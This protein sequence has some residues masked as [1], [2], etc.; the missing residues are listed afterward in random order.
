[1]NRKRQQAEILFQAGQLFGPMLK[2]VENPESY[3]QD[4]RTRILARYFADVQ[5]FVGNFREFIN[6]EPGHIYEGQYFK[7]MERIGPFGSIAGLSSF[8]H[9]AD[10]VKAL[11]AAVFDAIYSIPVPIDSSIHEAH[12]PFSTYCLV[13]A[14]CSTARARIDW[15]DRYFDATLFGRYFVDVPETSVITLVT[16]PESRC[17]GAKDRQRYTDFMGVS[18]LYALERGPDKYRLMTA[19]DF[20]DRRL[21]CDDKMLLLGDSIK[22]LGKN[23][24]FTTSRLDDTDDNRRNFDEAIARATEVFGPTNTAHP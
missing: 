14:M 19:E 2:M 18:R 21:R 22:D 4:E 17:T 8:E 6:G 23:S 9:L 12:T 7:A 11:S 24:T 10:A 3:D 5:R 15:M 20:H 1:M 13:K 16:W